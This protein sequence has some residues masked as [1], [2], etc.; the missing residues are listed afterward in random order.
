MEG[1]DLG[2]IKRV[3]GVNKSWAIDSSEILYFTGG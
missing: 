2:M 3:G 1:N